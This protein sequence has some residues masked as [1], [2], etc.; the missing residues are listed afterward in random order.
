MPVVRLVP[1]LRVMRLAP[2]VPRV[3]V[4]RPPE[5]PHIRYE[6][7]CPVTILGNA[8][9]ILVLRVGR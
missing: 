2:V 6:R 1:I 9:A 3:A 5:V 4:V 8:T 7:T